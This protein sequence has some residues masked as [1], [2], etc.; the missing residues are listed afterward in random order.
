MLVLAI[1]P[2]A[3][4]ARQI[5]EV[6]PAVLQ[7]LHAG[8]IPAQHGT[9]LRRVAAERAIDRRGIPQRKL[10]H[11]VATVDGVGQAGLA[12]GHAQRP[13]SHSR[14]AELVKA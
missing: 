11:Q 4:G 5:E 6:L 7:A 1:H 10:T 2:L 8:T 13:R 12:V 14:T 3:A 9:K